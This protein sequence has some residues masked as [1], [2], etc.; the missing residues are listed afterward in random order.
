MILLVPEDH[1]V[2]SSDLS[3][4]SSNPTDHLP[5]TAVASFSAAFVL[6]YP[7][8]ADWLKTW[9]ELFSSVDSGLGCVSGTS[10]LGLVIR[11][12][13]ISIFATGMLGTA[14]VPASTAR[15]AGYKHRSNIAHRRTPASFISSTIN[16]FL[17]D[18]CL[19]F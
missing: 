10:M 13:G 14:I 5:L 8:L 6:S 12:F 19:R 11:G 4:R 17:G 2:R 7:E 15:A 18:A 3:L 1:R 9:A 16:Y